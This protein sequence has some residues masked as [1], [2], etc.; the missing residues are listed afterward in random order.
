MERHR[1]E[2]RILCV[3]A[4]IVLLALLLAGCYELLWSNGSAFSS[5]ENR[6]LA[7]RPSF[8]WGSFLDGTFADQMEKYLA[9]RFPGRGPIIDR[10]REL[11]Q[12]GSLATWED[13]SRVAESSVQSIEFTEDLSGEDVPVTPQPTRTPTPVPAP[14]V[15]PGPAVDGKESDPG[16]A[17]TPEPTASPCPTNTPRPTKE[18]AD[19]D[20]FP[21]ELRFYL[22]TGNDRSN[23][24]IQLRN[25][26][27]AQCSLYDAYASVLPEG[28]MF[29]MTIPP[30]STR[31]TR[32]KSFAD[33]KGMYSDIEPFIHAVTAENVSVVS[34]VDLLSGPILNGEYVYF[35]TDSHWTPYGAHIVVQKMM[36]EAG[37]AL[38]PY[39]AF[40]RTQEYPFLGTLYRDT[41]NVQ[42]KNNPD[43]LDIVTP[44]RPVRAR[45]YS[46]ATEYS[47]V[48]F[49]KTD[50]NPRDRY[51]V[52]LGGPSGCLTVV[53]RTDVPQEEIEK[54]CLVI[55]DSYGLCA[56]P[57]F[58]EVYD[59]AIVYDP[60]YYDR[61]AMGSVSDL[62]GAWGVQ[63]IYMIVGDHD[64]YDTERLFYILC[65]RHF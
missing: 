27:Y 63:D 15:T 52:Y 28:G 45:R 37:E 60:R 48:P 4:W 17:S 49:I 1:R 38:P 57:F 50:A 51:S 24:T 31:S 7:E 62:I 33:P 59:R 8:T 13:Y 11:R 2:G 19:V 56:M 5:Q 53:E 44:T 46:T 22:W 47:E 10:T 3:T 14:T 65:N 9:D 36:E 23:V 54:T 25:V 16:S 40:P 35:Q 32:L 12:L 30:H 26:I 55:A 29:V 61:N 42:M 20:S 58:A 6:M 21:R 41:L 64:F 39:D 43:T 18:P 34:A